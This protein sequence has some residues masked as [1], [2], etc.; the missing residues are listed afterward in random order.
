MSLHD[1]KE[2]S[3]NTFYVDLKRQYCCWSHVISSVTQQQQMHPDKGLCVDRS[4]ELFQT[5]SSCIY[6]R[7]MWWRLKCNNLAQ[8]MVCLQGVELEACNQHMQ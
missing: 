1:Q 8:Y 2:P 6:V 3:L 4:L 7:S 5:I